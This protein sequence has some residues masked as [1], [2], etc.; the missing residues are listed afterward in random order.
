MPVGGAGH[1]GTAE[2]MRRTMAGCVEAVVADAIAVCEVPAPT[3]HE[4]ERARLVAAR[5]RA[6]GLG[7]PR[8]DAAGNV[9]CELAGRPDRPQVVLMAH[10]DTVFGPDVD[11]RVQ[12]DGTRLR[13]PGIGDNSV[14]VAALLWLG[15]ALADLPDRGT[16][17]L[18]ANVGE[19]GLGNLRGARALWDAYGMTAGA[20]LVLEGGT[21]NRAVR[22]G[23]SSRRLPVTYR[24]PGGHSWQDFGR[25]S[26]IHALGR[27]IDQL[28]GL[29]VPRDPKT[30]YNVGRVQGGTTVNTIAAEASLTLDMRSVD[31]SALEVLDRA[32]RGLVEAVARAAGVE[33]AVEVVGDRAGG[34]LSADHPLVQTVERAAAALG[35]AVTWEAASTD[36]NV[37]LSHGAACVCLGLA[38]GEGAHTLEETLD[39]TELTTGLTQAALVAAALLRGEVDLTARR[40]RPDG[41]VTST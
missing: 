31:P 24:G 19:E 8:L 30:T 2:A 35:T 38:R 32:A 14:A 4:A 12:R 18:A 6:L 29:R 41:P 13:A 27:L 23:V 26:A 22:E 16:L 40:G 37:P 20:W 28:A 7:S 1:D 33:A 9:V 5:M 39:T 36:A 10:L 21:F 34:G 3:F 11:V 15:R 25:P 17:V